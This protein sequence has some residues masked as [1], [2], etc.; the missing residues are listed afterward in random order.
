VAGCKRQRRSREEDQPVSSCPIM[1]GGGDGCEEVGGPTCTSKFAWRRNVKNASN[2]LLLRRI[3]GLS[4]LQQSSRVWRV[5]TT[6]SW[7]ATV[8][9]PSWCSWLDACMIP[10]NPSSFSPGACSCCAAASCSIWRERKVGRCF[11]QHR[12]KLRTRKLG[13]CFNHLHRDKLSRWFTAE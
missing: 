3:R 8:F 4:K 5:R 1:M 11:Y 2:Y 13:R 10:C 7:K 6:H 9:V 12:D